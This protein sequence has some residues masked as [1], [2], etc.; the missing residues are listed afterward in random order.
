[1]YK[2]YIKRWLDLM[3]SIIGLPFFAIVFIILA[4]I[5]V[6]EDKGSVFYNASRL[7][8]NGKVFKMFKFRS[9]KVNAPDLRNE[10]GSTYNSDNDPRV[11]KI[12][13]IMRKTSLDEVPQILNILRGEMSLIGPRPD[14]EDALEVF[15]GDEIEKLSVRPGITGYSQA[16]HRNQIDLHDRFK[17]DVYYA[18]NVSFMLDLKI[19]FQTIRTV[20]LRK[21]VYRDE[22]GRMVTEKK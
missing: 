11:T 22:T 4:P 5:I 6:L 18:K 16:Y 21:G 19:F 3:I 12:G 15:Q 9:M 20:L 2:K 17:E 13:R 8:R 7:G 1:M 10:D 14:L